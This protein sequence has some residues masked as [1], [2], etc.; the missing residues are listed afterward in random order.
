MQHKGQHT[1]TEE[2]GNKSP[3]Q[4]RKK[5]ANI[6]KEYT[7]RNKRHDMGEGKGLKLLL[8]IKKKKA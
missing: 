5:S 7:G 8:E 6:K 1:K 4:V 3:P 2:R